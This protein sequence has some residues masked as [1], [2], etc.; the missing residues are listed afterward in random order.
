MDKQIV[1]ALWHNKR[2]AAKALGITRQAIQNWP[3]ELPLFQRDRVVG[4]AIR[5]GKVRDLVELGVL[6]RSHLSLRRRV[7]AN[8]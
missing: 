2:R 8:A 4:A 1:I 3:D 7:T 6:D 5:D